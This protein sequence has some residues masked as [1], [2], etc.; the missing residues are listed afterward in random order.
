MNRHIVRRALVGLVGAGTLLATAG[1]VATAQEAGPRA[2]MPQRGV[3]G[4]AYSAQSQA[5]R[6]LT[7]GARIHTQPSTGSTVVGYG[8]QTHV[9]TVHCRRVVA[10]AEWFY[11]TDNATNVTGWGRYDVVV[12]YVAVGNC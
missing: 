11:H 12:P 7:D 3:M 8:Y 9:V 10:G 1:S 4:A 6:Y 2:A 5:G